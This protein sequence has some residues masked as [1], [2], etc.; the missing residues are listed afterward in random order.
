MV[1]MFGVSGTS[2]SLVGSLG[3]ISLRFFLDL[4]VICQSIFLGNFFPTFYCE[5]LSIFDVECLIIM[6]LSFLVQSLECSVSFLYHYRHVL[7]KEFI[8]F[9]FKDLY[10]LHKLVPTLTALSGRTL[11]EVRFESDGQ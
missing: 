6:G 4:G 5:E 8:H 7:P 11:T 10:R 1:G 9:F 3:G 2:S